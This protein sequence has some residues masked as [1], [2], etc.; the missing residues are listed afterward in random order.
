[1]PPLKVLF[2]AFIIAV[3]LESSI[4]LVNITFFPKKLVLQYKYNLSKK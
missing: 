2:C 1:M 4:A 3:G